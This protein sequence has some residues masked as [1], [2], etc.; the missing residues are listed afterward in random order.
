MARYGMGGSRD[1]DEYRSNSRGGG[2]DGYVPQQ[3]RGS[4]SDDDMSFLDA[5]FNG[6]N[7]NKKGKYKPD[8]DSEKSDRYQTGVSKKHIQT[9]D[10]Y[11]RAAKGHSS[12]L[13]Q[14]ESGA[15]NKVSNYKTKVDNSAINQFQIRTSADAKADGAF[16]A[17]NKFNNNARS[18]L[19]DAKSDATKSDKNVTQQMHGQLAK[20]ADYLKVRNKNDK[21]AQGDPDR[22]RTVG[23]I[24]RRE[25]YRKDN[26]VTTKSGATVFTRRDGSTVRKNQDGSRKITH[27]NEDGSKD[28]TKKN[29]EGKKLKQYNLMIGETKGGKTS[30]LRTNKDGSTR[31]RILNEK[32]DVIRQ[33]NTGTNERGL[34]VTTKTNRK[35]DTSKTILNKKGKVKRTVD[36]TTNKAGKEV[37]TVTDKKGGRTTKKIFNKKGDVI[38][39]FETGTNKKGLAINTTTNRKGETSKTVLNKRG[40]VKKTVDTKLNKWGNRVVTTTDKKGNSTVSRPDK[41]KKNNGGEDS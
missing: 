34:S 23:K 38:R 35:G 32:G 41:K 24:N 25:K 22:F 10:P 4:Y 9:V 2:R 31:K 21:K 6:S 14:I 17:G 13:D 7:K 26:T 33:V 28:I 40:K 18:N 15:E 29:S 20:E 19:A 16:S 11:G 12:R 3:S 36:N 37:Q 5:L 27:F 1:Q 39:K 8:Y 30:R